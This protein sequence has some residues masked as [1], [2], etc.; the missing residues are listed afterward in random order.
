VTEPAIALIDLVIGGRGAA[1]IIAPLNAALKRAPSTVAPGFPAQTRRPRRFP[2]LV[3]RFFL[4]ALVCFLQ[5]FAGFVQGAEG[6]VVGLGRLAVLADGAFALAGD[7][8][9]LAELDVA[10]DFGPARLA[11]PIN[12]CPVGVGRRLVVPLIEENLGDAVVGEGT[13]LC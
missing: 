11:V 6:V 2:I 10:P 5:I 8:E 4:G 12:G 3:G 7:I 13:V 1:S 9:N